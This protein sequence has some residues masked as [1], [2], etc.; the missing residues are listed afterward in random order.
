MANGTKTRRIF[1]S[2][3]DFLEFGRA[4]LAEAFPNPEREGCPPDQLLRL[5]AYKPQQTDVL[6]ADHITC[7]SPCFNAYMAYLEHAR[8]EERESSKSRHPIWVSR[9]AVL[10]SVACLIVIVISVF[11]VKWH[12]RQTVAVLAPAPINKHENANHGSAA[13]MHIPVLIDLTRATA[14]RGVGQSTTISSKPVL[15]S[16]S[17]VAL[18]LRLPLGSETTLYSVRLLSRGNTAWAG[19]AHAHIENRQTVLNLQADFRQIPEGS[20]ELVVASEGLHITAPVLLQTA[21]IN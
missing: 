10:A 6:I 14:S 8:I 20:Y 1:E 3:R 11:F 4:Y 9:S 19:R 21:H 2:D 13:A 7:C 17:R 15:P 5:L 16:H 12:G 18:T